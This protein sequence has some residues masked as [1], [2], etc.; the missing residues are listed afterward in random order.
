MLLACLGVLWFCFAE[1]FTLQLDVLVHPENHDEATFINATLTAF[2]LTSAIW[3]GV[4]QAISFAAIVGLRKLRPGLNLHLL[5]DGAF[6][7]RV[8]QRQRDSI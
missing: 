2:L 1:I 4:R 8:C 6:D 3:I 5:P 7:R